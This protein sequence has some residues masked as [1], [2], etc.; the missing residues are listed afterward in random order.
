MITFIYA[1]VNGLSTFFRAIKLPERGIYGRFVLFFFLRVDPLEEII[2]EPLFLE[3]VAFS[4][5]K[6]VLRRLLSV[7]SQNLNLKIILLPTMGF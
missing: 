6:E 3:V 2:M 7:E 5:I 4:Q 1:G